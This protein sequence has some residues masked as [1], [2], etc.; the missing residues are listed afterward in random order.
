MFE[1]SNEN[2]HKMFVTVQSFLNKMDKMT[3]KQ[4]KDDVYCAVCT[5][6]AGGLC[7]TLFLYYF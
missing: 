3:G 7:E 5:K 4:K 1:L 2:L 6:S